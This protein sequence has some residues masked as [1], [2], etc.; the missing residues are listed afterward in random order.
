MI[1]SLYTAANTLSTMQSGIDTIAHNIA[2][3]EATGYKRVRMD[4]K[5]ALYARMASPADNSPAMNLQRGAGALVGQTLRIFNQGPMQST[6]RLLDLYLEGGGFLTVAMPDGTQSYTRNGALYVSLSGQ[7]AYLTDAHGYY[8]LDENGQRIAVD[9]HP[10]SLVIGEDGTLSWVAEGDGESW[11]FARL[12]L[13]MFD[14]PSGLQ[15]TQDGFFVPTANSG[16]ARGDTGTAVRQ[17]Y[18]EGSNVD[19]AEETTRLIRTQRAFQLASRAI[20][21]ADQMMQLANTIRA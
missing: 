6:E 18:L 19:L 20:N 10:E 11:P 21:T 9:G 1:Q 7:E 3:M 17:G 8:I 12:G 4:F 2:N 14:N 16:A 13:V 5:E 15:A